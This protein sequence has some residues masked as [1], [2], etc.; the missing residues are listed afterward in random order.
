MVR[1]LQ[2]FSKN[3]IDKPLKVKLLLFIMPVIVLSVAM[4]GFFSYFYAIKQIKKNADDLLKGTVY[5]TGTFVNDRLAAIFEQLVILENEPSFQRLL[6]NDYPSSERFQR[7]HDVIDFYNQ[8]NQ[9]YQRY[10]PMVDSIYFQVNGRELQIFDEAPNRVGIHL[11]EWLSKY[12]GSPKGYYWLNDHPD[13]VFSTVRQRHVITIFKVLDSP[14]TTTKGILLIN[15]KSDYFKELLTNGSL[16]NNSYLVLSSPDGQLFSDK[17]PPRYGVTNSIWR[18]LFRH[19]PTQGIMNIKSRMGRKLLLVFFQIKINRWSVA[20]VVP[21]RDLLAEVGKI[22]KTVWVI[23]LLVVC[24]AT[25]ATVIIANGLVISLNALVK[26]VRR[27][28]NG[29]YNIQFNHRENNEIG[30]LA[31]A[32]NGMLGT[33][34]DLLYKIQTEQEQKRQFELNAL[35]AQINPHFLYNTLGSIKHLIDMK[36]NGQASKMVSALTNFFRIGISRGK[37]IITVAEELEHVR[38]YLM[39]QKM[40]Y[41]ENLDFEINVHPEIF[42]CYIIKL[43]LQPIVENSI[44]HGIKNKKNTLGMIKISGWGEGENVIIE[45]YDN[46]IGM[47]QTTLNQVKHSLQIAYQEETTVSIGLRNVNERI[48]LHFGSQYGLTVES[49]EGQY[50]LVQVKIPSS[51]F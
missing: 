19:H 38:N 16:D 31:K 10:Y 42:N 9:T 43:I 36:E 3:I 7:L 25:L 13:Q 21:E 34:Q 15:L 48:R 30:V 44:Y 11:E 27:F 14:R 29:D 6:L 37:E 39:I 51:I 49:I 23:V 50:T 24:L 8:L 26:Q 28:E 5:Q 35:Q 46:G 32:L 17:V 45:I 4:T 40:R 47:D 41:Q 33:I 20:V 2:K 22:K 1:L 12:Q 18:N